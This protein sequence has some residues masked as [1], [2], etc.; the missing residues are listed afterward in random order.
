VRLL[1][2]EPIKQVD[3]T[4]TAN[5]VQQLLSNQASS[6]TQWLQPVDTDVH[7][8]HM[9]KRF[10]FQ[11]APVDGLTATQVA[12]PHFVRKFVRFSKNVLWQLSAPVV[13]SREVYLV[14]LSDS[15]AVANPGAI[16]GFVK[17]YYQDG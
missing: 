16:A 9:D 5:F 12:R 13:P 15:A 2:V 4:S 17:L 10:W 3:V 6:G 8:V 1:L 14:A 7:K 11:F